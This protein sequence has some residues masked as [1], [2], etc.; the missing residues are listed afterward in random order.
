MFVKLKATKHTCLFI[1]N[2]SVLAESASLGGHFR[3][4]LQQ[5]HLIVLLVSGLISLQE[6]IIERNKL[7]FMM[8]Q[9][10]DLLTTKFELAIANNN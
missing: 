10:F 9:H 1:S 5:T 7:N 4:N 3:E 6:S 8:K 2:T